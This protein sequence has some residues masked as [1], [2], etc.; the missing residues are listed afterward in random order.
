MT[1]QKKLIEAIGEGMERQGFTQKQLASAASMTQ[2]MV[3]MALKGQ[4]QLTEEKWRAMCG[5][6]AI[7]Y[8][9]IVAEPEVDFA[10]IAEAVCS[11]AEPAETAGRAME[12]MVEST[13]ATRETAMP[14]GLDIVARYV[15]GKLREDI[16]HGTDM[17]LAELR[18]LLDVASMGG[19]MDE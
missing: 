5:A 17:S 2:S 16:R 10:A 18:V 19:A 6:L 11:M 8:D 14:G 13:T 15:A 7:D 4:Y 1:K 3:S 12:T 9:A